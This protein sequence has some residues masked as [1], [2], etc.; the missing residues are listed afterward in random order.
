LTVGQLSARTGV[1]VKALRRYTD[2]GLVNTLG[3]SAGNYR[4]FPADAV[5]CLEQIAMLRELGLTLAEIRQ[6]SAAYG[7]RRVGPLL[8]QFLTR[9]AARLDAQMAAAQQTRRRID[10]FADEHHAMLAGR[11]AHDLWPGALAGQRRG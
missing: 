3:R 9:A 6:L 4:L 1:P 2:W 11:S 5:Y 8:A 10:R 7:S